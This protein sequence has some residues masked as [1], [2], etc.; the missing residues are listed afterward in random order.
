VIICVGFFRKGAQSIGVILTLMR[1][2][3]VKW[4]DIETP[5][6]NRTDRSVCDSGTIA[7]P[8]RFGRTIR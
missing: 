1:Q 3:A 4:P 2:G 8:L 7:A 6:L 5:P